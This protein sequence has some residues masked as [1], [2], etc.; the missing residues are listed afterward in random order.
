MGDGVSERAIERLND[1][2]DG[3]M[4]KRWELKLKN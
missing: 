2:T 3:E 4:E 1:G